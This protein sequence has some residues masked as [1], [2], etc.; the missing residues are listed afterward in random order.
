MDE[1]SPERKA[2][3]HEELDRLARAFDRLP[4]KCR[5]VVWLRRV[6][7]LSQSE[8]AKR[9]NLAEKTVEKHLRLGARLLAHY[10]RANVLMPRTQR[11]RDVTHESEHEIQAQPRD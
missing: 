7:E 1:I 10:A 6:K 4:A 2:A 8:V 3:A 5:E 11:A 9:L